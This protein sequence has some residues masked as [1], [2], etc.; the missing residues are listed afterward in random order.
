MGGYRGV[1]KKKPLWI[2]V[3][4]LI[5]SIAT[6]DGELGVSWLKDE[7]QS[8][9]ECF[10]LVRLVGKWSKTNYSMSCPW[11]YQL[12]RLLWELV[13]S[14]MKDLKSSSDLSGWLADGEGSPWEWNKTN[15][16][17]E[18]GQKGKKHVS[19]EKKKTHQNSNSP[20]II[21]NFMRI[22]YLKG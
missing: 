21:F 16:Q 11:F 8:I 1:E 15:P 3:P 12:Q 20:K 4:S 17:S 18:R 9:K 22:F 13:V 5:V 7:K 10:K 6:P 2:P 19:F 14:L